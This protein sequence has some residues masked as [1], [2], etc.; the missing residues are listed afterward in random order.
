MRR[1]IGSL[2][3]GLCALAVATAMF[4][5]PVIAHAVEVWRTVE[6]FSYGYFILPIAVGL[7]WWRRGALRASIGQGEVAGLGVAT[8]AAMAVVLAPRVGINALAGAAVSPLLWGGAV[9][10]WGWRTGRVL[11]FPIGFLAFGLAVYRG[12][13]SSLGFAL[14]GVTATAAAGLGR[15]LGLGVVQDGLVLRAQGFAFVVAEQCSGMSSLLSLLALAALW[16][17]L[18]QGTL[19]ARLA[20]VLSVLPLV[21]AANVTRVTLVLLVASLCGQE[22]AVG[23]FHGASSLAFFGVAVGGLLLLSRGLKCRVGA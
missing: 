19:P 23:F 20:L 13:L 22:A 3:W 1:R 8:V 9:F 17:H 6:E 15:G 14:Q 21:V 18:A 10:L 11:A 4:L 2:P 16:A 5:W 7:V 12:L